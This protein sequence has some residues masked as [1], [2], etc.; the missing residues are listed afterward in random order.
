VLD[1]VT[2]NTVRA[3]AVP[4]PASMVLLGTG[5]FGGVARRWRQKRKTSVSC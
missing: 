3:T 1:N 4:E 2:V 5:L